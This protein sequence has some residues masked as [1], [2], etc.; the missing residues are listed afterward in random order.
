MID[1][2]R[3]EI[4]RALAGRPLVALGEVTRV[5][6]STQRARV[7]LA[8][9]GNETGWLRIATAAAGTLRP[10]RC[11]DEVKVCFLDGDPGGSGIIEHC[12]YGAARVPDFP[13]NSFGAAQGNTQVI[14]DADGN[15]ALTVARVDVTATGLVAIDG[16]QVKLGGGTAA[17]VKYENLEAA[18]NAWVPQLIAAF[19][20]AQPPVAVVI[21]P[22][23][24]AAARATKVSI[25]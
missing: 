9:T 10:L 23:V 18:L 20:A 24:L 2:I 12:L 15:I 3:S 11:G 21:T 16:T 1:T 4:R 8:T 7:R 6:W 25:T 22:P 17:A 14:Y 13:E 19:A 5:D